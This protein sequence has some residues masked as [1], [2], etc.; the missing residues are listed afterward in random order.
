M[1]L[2]SMVMTMKVNDNE[3]DNNGNAVND[4]GDN[5]INNKCRQW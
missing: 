4:D 5:E 1:E 3:F 2:L